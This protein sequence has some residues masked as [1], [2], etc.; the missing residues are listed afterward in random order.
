MMRVGGL[1]VALV[2]VAGACA[3]DPTGVAAECTDDTG[4]VAVS[5][6]PGLTPVFSWDPSCAVALLLVEQE[7][8]DQWGISTDEATWDD[9]SQANRISPP[10]TYGVTPASASELSAPEDLTA[11]VT[12][13]LVLWRV[14]PD[15]STAQCMQTLENLCLMAVHEFTP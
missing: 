13:E 2:V 14:L 1:A 12:Y 6:G 11:G 8:S 5:V 4:T 9:P 10:I 3:D 7:A 15:G